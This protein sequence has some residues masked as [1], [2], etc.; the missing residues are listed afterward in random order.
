MG[1][2]LAPH[3]ETS[4]HI[5][6]SIQGK[7]VTGRIIFLC[8]QCQFH[9]FIIPNGSYFL[10]RFV[11]QSNSKH[12]IT[13]TPPYNRRM[14]AV[15][16]DQSFQMLVRTLPGYIFFQIQTN[17]TTEQSC[18]IQYHQAHFIRQIIVNTRPG[19]CMRTNGISSKILNHLI[20]CISKTSRTDISTE[21][22]LNI[23]EAL[24]F[25]SVQLKLISYNFKLSPSETGSFA[26]IYLLLPV[27]SQQQS[28]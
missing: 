18:L 24:Y 17:G 23:P 22:M 15:T 8:A 11:Q 7:E 14:I 28:V 20:P 1:K 5:T 2:V 9:Q 21:R 19:L 13:D 16:H 12:L 4:V 25:L 26:V 3:G 6:V 27:Y 10:C